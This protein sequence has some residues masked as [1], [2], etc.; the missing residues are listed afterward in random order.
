[1][2][3]T[4]KKTETERNAIKGE[5]QPVVPSFTGFPVKFNVACPAKKIRSNECPKK[6]P[7][8]KG[9][10]RRGGGIRK[11][12]KQDKP[13]PP[14]QKKLVKKKVQ[15]PKRLWKRSRKVVES[16]IDRVA[17]LSRPTTGGWLISERRQCHHT[18]AAISGLSIGH[19]ITWP[20]HSK[21]R[22]PA[23]QW[24]PSVPGSC[25]LHL[26]L[27]LSIFLFIFC[28]KHLSWSSSRL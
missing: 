18:T 6:M 12:T 15:P 24:S 21:R 19:V 4:W 3:G 9:G 28:F 14:P 20:T 1:M 17:G 13:P 22:R 27:S 26:S 23:D 11:K 5:Q 16:V 10:R 2:N 8:R 7:K 25:S